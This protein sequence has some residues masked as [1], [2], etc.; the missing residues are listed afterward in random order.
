M[1]LQT[2]GYPRDCEA[3]MAVSL[4]SQALKTLPQWFLTVALAPSQNYFPP[5]ESQLQLV[6]RWHVRLLNLQRGHLGGQAPSEKWLLWCH[7]K[8]NE[9]L[10]NFT[11]TIWYYHYVW[12]KNKR[13]AL[14][15]WSSKVPYWYFIFIP[16]VMAHCRAICNKAYIFFSKQLGQW[17]RIKIYFIYKTDHSLYRKPNMLFK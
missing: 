12:N 11:E 17:R 8:W 16:I 14:N 10:P 9:V 1:P 4:P 3:A 2:P 13:A 5:G 7:F 15:L 6:H